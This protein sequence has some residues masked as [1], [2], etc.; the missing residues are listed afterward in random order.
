MRLISSIAE[1]KTF[2]RQIHAGGKSLALVPTMGALHDGHLSLVRQ[3]QRQCDA[4]VVSIFVNPLQFGPAEDFSRYPRNLDAD[5]EFL[6]PFNVEAVFTPSAAE[7]YPEGFETFLMPGET[8]SSLEGV[9]RPGHFRGVATAVLKLFN[10]VRPEV[11]YF[12]QKDF[13]QTVVVRRLVEELNL[14]VR[15]II[16]PTVRDADGLAKTS[17]AAYLSDEHR[18]AARVLYRSLRRA[19]ELVQA[20]QTDAHKILEEMRAV[21]A[22]E[23]Q[24]KLDYVAIVEPSRLR[25]VERVS[26]GCVALVAAQV[27]STRLVDNT[28]FGPPGAAPELLLQLALTAVP[29]LDVRARIPGLETDTLRRRIEGCRDCAALSSILLPPREFLVKYLKRDYPDLNAVRVL[30]IGRDSPINPENLLYRNPESTNRFVSSLFDLVG[31]KNFVEF[32]QRF[33]LTDSLRCHASGSR[34]PDKALEHCVRHLR[35]ELK[36]FANLESVV[37]LGFDAYMQFQ[38]FILG[39]SDREFKPFNQVLGEQGWAAEE[40]RIPFLGDRAIRVFYC[41]HPTYEYKRSPSIA[42]M[43]GGIAAEPQTPAPR[44]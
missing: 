38:R 13:Q 1:M 24:A 2:A 19:E 35:E 23:P 20:D 40:V 3:A 11:A 7:M 17:R 39:R 10:I 44:P 14:D 37:V 33:A 16:C 30:V 29:V 5:L 41:H 32:T 43:L 9:S 6:R 18:Q 36:L 8:A 12:G 22:Q 34:I 28:I 31:V 25:P 42:S 21:F 27:G 4:V 26:G 15:L